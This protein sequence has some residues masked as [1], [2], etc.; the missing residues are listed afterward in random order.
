[1]KAHDRP[2]WVG[3]DSSGS[4]PAAE[5]SLMDG[6]DLYRHQLVQF[7]ETVM[8]GTS[9]NGGPWSMCSVTQPERFGALSRSPRRQA[10]ED[11]RLWVGR[12]LR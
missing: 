2:V 10:L 8:F 6:P 3:W 1:M 9:V 11:F 4:N 7:G 5:W 12:F